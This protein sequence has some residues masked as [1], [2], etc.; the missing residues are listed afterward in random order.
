MTRAPGPVPMRGAARRSGI[1]SS[2]RG[3]TTSR[4]L[5]RRA[6]K[7]TDCF[8]ALTDPTLR[9]PRSGKL[10]IAAVVDPFTEACLSP[11]SELIS[12]HRQTWRLQLELFRPD[13]LF[14]ESAW[15]GRDSSWTRGIASYDGV[16]RHDDLLRLVRYCR[17]RDIATVF[18]N[19]EDPVHFDRFV[20]AAVL[21][22]V[23]LT[24]DADCVPAYRRADGHGSR[25]ILPWSFAA[26][27]L[28]H[29]PLDADPAPTVCFAG[30]WGEAALEQR[31]SDLAYLLEACSQHRLT[32]YDRTWSE[33]TPSS[34]PSHIRADVRPG[35]G[36]RDIC[37]VYRAHAAFINVN[38]VT[39]S[40]TMFARRVYELLAC[41]A[42][43]VSNPSSGMVRIFG[44]AV[45]VSR[46]RFEA[47]E[48]LAYVLGDMPRRRR[49]AARTVRLVLSQH[50]YGMRMRELRAT[51]G[52]H[53]PELHAP[54][55]LV[56]SGTH[57][58]VRRTLHSVRT[59]D[60]SMSE[61]VVLWTGKSSDLRVADL[62][63]GPLRVR[64]EEVTGS[65]NEPAN[66]REAATRIAANDVVMFSSS[67]DYGPEYATSLAV[68]RTFSDADIIAKPLD[69]DARFYGFGPAVDLRG[70]M[71]R[72]AT[73]VERGWSDRPDHRPSGNPGSRVL[74]SDPDS[75]TPHSIP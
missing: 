72:A 6:A 66:V 17:S 23:I 60:L 47:E 48:A 53:E 58:D 54:A 74:V 70:A 27:P 45:R 59:Q 43:V 12:L 61:A 3:S 5:R 30:S 26:Q 55:A 57:D 19:K 10:R 63:C 20:D 32:I 34:F 49:E 8:R 50:T 36:Y 28:L 38:T 31:R 1:S 40:P 21:F 25:P 69:P 51:L 73:L 22:D 39:D 46:D 42:S 65:T 67:A 24:T 75:F 2:G 44:D 7:V 15:R 29:N 56:V 64:V 4:A 11:E 33:G 52:L 14:V 13:V 18:W 16:A 37:D 35:V 71:F 41:G 62:D 9:T 68:C